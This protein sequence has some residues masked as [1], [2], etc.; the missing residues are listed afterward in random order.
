[1]GREEIERLRPRAS[2]YT[3]KHPSVD[4]LI[5]RVT[6][7]GKKT[8]A[9][10]YSLWGRDAIYTIGGWPEIGEEQAKA[11]TLRVKAAVARREDPAAELRDRKAIAETVADLADRFLEERALK[12]RT[13]KSYRQLVAA[14]IKPRL[15]ALQVQD[16][17]PAHVKRVHHELRKTPRT[18][19]HVIAVLSAMLTE[20]EH[21]GLRPAGSNPCATIKRYKETKRQRYLTADELARVYEALPS[22]GLNALHEGALRLLL[23][24]GMRRSEVLGLRWAHVDLEA[25]R[26]R[27]T[28][29]K[30][31]ARG[32]R[33]V[34]L[35][36][37]ALAVL[38]GLPKHRSPFVFTGS[39][40]DG[41]IGASI[42]HAWIS[43]RTKA[44]CPDVR[45]HDIRHTYASRG[46][47]SGMSLAQV[48]LLL[49]HSS[50]A[51]TAR[52]SH[53]V[54]DAARA[55]AERAE[56]GMAPEK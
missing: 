24:T 52:Y 19:N 2:R 38:R 3:V 30:T 1:M 12:P 15:G 25:G 55:L 46:I 13:L 40:K 35:G 33:I 54:E 39:G 21:W 10:R 29:H 16:L 5:L 22:C 6:P 17:G 45:L 43:V 32:E 42:D 7:A 48:G 51:T 49:G 50:P 27:L 56:A 53:L 47:A 36:P 4:G 11:E 26:L 9:V 31:D 14:Y 28:E 37:E 34:L 18:A 20:A 41:T 44:G 23:L 8:W